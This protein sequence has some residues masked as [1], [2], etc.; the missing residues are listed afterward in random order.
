VTTLL[1]IAIPLGLLSLLLR[2]LGRLLILK[3][4]AAL[5]HAAAVSQERGGSVCLDRLFTQLA[6]TSPSWVTSN[7][8]DS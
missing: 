7:F 5:P 4:T 8:V 2:I 6:A 1:L 3:A